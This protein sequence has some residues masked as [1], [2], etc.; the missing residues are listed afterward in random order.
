MSGVQ[1]QRK[2]F[3][4]TTGWSGIL[5]QAHEV[6]FGWAKSYDGAQLSEIAQEIYWQVQ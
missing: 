6:G 1:K 4:N 3:Q 5:D 2:T